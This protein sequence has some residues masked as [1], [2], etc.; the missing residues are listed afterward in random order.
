M[1]PFKRILV[2]LDG[3]R[4]AEAVLP[5]A[6]AVAERCGSTVM[7]LHVLEHN[8]PDT[9]H[10]EPH[11]SDI[12]SAHRYL[13]EVAERYQESSVPTES[14]VHE[15]LEHNVARSIAE[16]AAELAV[17]L[18]ALA[19]HGSGG[20]RGFLFGSIAQQAL[21][22]TSVPVLLV[23]PESSGT[24]HDSFQ[25]ILVPLDGTPQAQFALPVAVMLATAAHAALH[26]VRVVPTVGT[27]SSSSGAATFSPSATAALL[28]IEGEEAEGALSDLRSEIPSEVQVTQEVRRGDVVDELLE[29]VERAGSD[30]IVMSTHGR[31]GLDGLW[32]GSVA[33]R[34]IGRLSRPVILV[35]ITSTTQTPTA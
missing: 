29:G 10:G 15:N 14:H 27:I 12:T 13:A 7:L 26:L 2:P 3:S 11:L 22:Q 30:L 34:L 1:D 16:H 32:T 6:F 5:S 17:D 20:L 9:V 23:R 21:R 24:Q 35:P 25:R 28:D 33:S 18:I 19:T 31:A 8:A 4:L